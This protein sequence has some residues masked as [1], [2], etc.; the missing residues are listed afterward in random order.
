MSK[1]NTA[2]AQNSEIEINL[3]SGKSLFASR[4]VINAMRENK[5][6]KGNVCPICNDGS[7]ANGHSICSGCFDRHGRILSNMVAMKVTSLPGHQWGE[8]CSTI[9]KIAREKG[10]RAISG[11]G[12]NKG[13]QAL[14]IRN[15]L[16]FPVPF[17]ATIFSAMNFIARKLRK[18]NGTAQTSP[19][20]NQEKKPA[21][22]NLKRTNTKPTTKPKKKDRNRST[23][24]KPAFGT[25]RD[26]F[27]SAIN[28]K[29]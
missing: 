21:G 29:A 22:R 15:K 8:L 3:G 10:I 2:N 18:E 4:E 13:K 26:A 27:K 1:K 6:A 11:S 19:Q 24:H 17:N 7:C 23:A 28:K 12:K 14:A 9:E 25:L 16:N 20:R 5:F